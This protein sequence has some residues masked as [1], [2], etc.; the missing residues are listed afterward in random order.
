M[1]GWG[2]PP[3]GG[4]QQWTDP[5]QAAAYQQYATASGYGYPGV[6][7]R[8]MILMLVHLHHRRTLRRLLGATAKAAM[9]V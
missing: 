2:G 7:V 8:H 3:P 1:S 9:S 6:C 4:S 5:N